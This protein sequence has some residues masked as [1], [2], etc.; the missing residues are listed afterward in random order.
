MFLSLKSSHSIIVSDINH[1]LERVH[2][3]RDV[4]PLLKDFERD[5]INYFRLQDDQFYAELIKKCC[6]DPKVLKMVRFF[7][8]DINLLK[9]DFFDFIDRFPLNASPTRA[10]QFSMAF[11]QF[12]KRILDRIAAEEEVLFIFLE[13]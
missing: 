5:L 10:R 7:K 4:Y 6:Y 11:Q 12:S 2:S 3:Y 9:V 13:Y 8:K 1:I